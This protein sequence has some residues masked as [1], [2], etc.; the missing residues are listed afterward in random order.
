[1]KLVSPDRF[2]SDVA[3]GTCEVNEVTAD[4]KEELPSELVLV[5]L[6]LTNLPLSFVVC[7]YVLLVLPGISEHP[8]GAELVAEGTALVQLNH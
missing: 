3:V 6:R 1:M 4:Q 5:V 8:L 2:G 7:V